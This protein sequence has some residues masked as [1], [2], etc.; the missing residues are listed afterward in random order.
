[1]NEKD[2]LY[3]CKLVELGNYTA[4]AAFFGVTQPTISMAIKRLGERFDDPLIMQ[5]NR[6]SKITL[7]DAGELLYKKAKILLQDIS[8]INY[9]V[10]HASDKKIRL[11]FSGEAGNFF[12]ADIIKKF[13]EAN[14]TNLIDTNIERSADAFSDLTNGDVDVAIYSWMVPINDPEYFIHNLKKTELVIITSL[15]DPWKDVYEISAADLRERK[16]VARARGY[17]TR[18]CLEEVGKLGNFS[19]NVIYTAKTMQT[20]IDL[21]KRNVGIALAMESSLEGESDLHIIR[22]NSSQKLFAYMQI[23]MRKSFVPNKYQ[24]KGIEILRN[25]KP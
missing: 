17:L 14:L 23:A 6:K 15:A 4:T 21:V 3:Y 9:D 19:P 16:F 13:Y 25:F 10:K 18:E 7:T 22:L 5:K 8:S 20:M 2:L 11:A 12:I 24:K 1:M